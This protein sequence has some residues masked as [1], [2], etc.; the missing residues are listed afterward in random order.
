MPAV[1]IAARAVG[2]HDHM[3]PDTYAARL[4]LVPVTLVAALI[5]AYAGAV[6]RRVMTGGPGKMK[7][8][9]GD[10]K[11]DRSDRRG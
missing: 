1:N 8:A 4:L 6:G 9:S 10:L 7:V 2:F 11:H 3:V 5:G